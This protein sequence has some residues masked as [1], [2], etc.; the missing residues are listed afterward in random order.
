[1]DEWNGMDRIGWK[2]IH[3]MDEMKIRFVPCPQP[4]EEKRKGNGGLLFS[5]F[6]C[7]FTAFFFLFSFCCFLLLLLLLR[8][9]KVRYKP[10][11]R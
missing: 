7:S 6:L 2:G 8:F 4:G 5:L 11:I 9:I 1:M 10:R 3:D